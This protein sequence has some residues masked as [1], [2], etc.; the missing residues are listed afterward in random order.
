MFRKDISY[1]ISQNIFSFSH[2][3][4]TKTLLLIHTVLV[5]IRISFSHYFATKPLVQIQ[6]YFSNYFATK[7]FVQ[8][9]KLDHLVRILYYFQTIWSIIETSIKHMRK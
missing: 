6:S 8:I 4:A 9:R 3:F 7:P 1:V 5:Q 2:Y